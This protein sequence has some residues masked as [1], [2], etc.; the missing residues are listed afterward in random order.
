MWNQVVGGVLGLAGSLADSVQKPTVSQVSTLSPIQQAVFAQK[1][2]K[3][4]DRSSA[5]VKGLGE[6]A[7]HRGDTYGGLGN[8][9]AQLKQQST[10]PAR[11]RMQGDLQSGNFRDKR[12]GQINSLLSQRYRDSLSDTMGLQ[13]QKMYDTERVLN[14]MLDR[15]DM[16]RQLGYAGQMNNLGSQLMTMDSGQQLQTP[17]QDPLA[18]AANAM[19]LGSSISGTLGNL[20]SQFQNYFGGRGSGTIG[21]SGASG[22]F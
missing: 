16:Q 6:A 5:S 10:I 7:T 11:E 17:R 21:S 9:E 3:E 12:H 1:F 18:T 14:S 20:G 13:K 4:W 22:G 15:S 2:G 19:N 8:W